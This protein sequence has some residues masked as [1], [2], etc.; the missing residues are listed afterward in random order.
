MSSFSSIEKERLKKNQTNLLNTLPEQVF[1]IDSNGSIEYMNHSANQFFS[2]INQAE[3]VNFHSNFSTFLNPDDFEEKPSKIQLVEFN[4]NTYSCNIAPFT[5]YNGDKLFWFTLSTSESTNNVSFLTKGQASIPV[6]IIGSSLI[7]KKLK[8]VATLIA[9][10]NATVLINGESGTGKDLVARLL[11][12]KSPRAHK[13]FLPINCTTI[14]DQLLESDLFGYEKGAFTGANCKTKGKFEKANGGT[15]FLDEIGD[16]SPR[17]QAVLLRVLQD[18]EVMRVGGTT[19]IK[20][21]VRVLAA[22]NQDLAEAVK[23]GTFRLDLF[24]RLNTFNIPIPPLRDRGDDIRELTEYLIQKYCSKFQTITRSISDSAIS[25]LKLHYWPGNVREL[26]NVIQRAVLTCNSKKIERKDISF[27]IP[28]YRG[29]TPSLM[30][31]IQRCARSPFKQTM[32]N[33]EKAII[34]TSLQQE[35]GNVERAA[36]KL[37]ISKATLYEKMKKH[38]ISAKDLRKN[39]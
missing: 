27:D 14:N 35:Y 20:V 15:I 7:I 30:P 1:L 16:I 32:E 36:K 3:K 38:T 29:T 33:I 9:R 17:M 10:T 24:Y 37:Q 5:G 21:D 39:N 34:Q 28:P 6:K 26:D 12:Q 23:L 25:K 31:I 2:Q 11:H 18:G 22:T 4:N 19:P 8:E 13:I